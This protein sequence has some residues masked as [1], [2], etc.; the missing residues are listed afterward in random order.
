MPTTQNPT[1]VYGPDPPPDLDDTMD[2]YDGPTLPDEPIPDGQGGWYGDDGTGIHPTATTYSTIVVGTSTTGYPTEYATPTPASYHR[3]DYVDNDVTIF[4]TRLAARDLAFYDGRREWSD[5]S[6]SLD[7]TANHL[8]TA[9]KPTPWISGYQPRYSWDY[10]SDLTGNTYAAIVPSMVFWTKDRTQTAYY[11]FEEVFNDFQAHFGYDSYVFKLDGYPAPQWPGMVKTVRSVIGSNQRP[12]ERDMYE[13]WFIRT[14]GQLYYLAPFTYYYD[15]MST[16]PG[17]PTRFATTKPVRSTRDDP[18]VPGDASVPSTDA[19]EGVSDDVSAQINAAVSAALSSA[20]I[21]QQQALLAQQAASDAD[22]SQALA[23]QQQLLTAQL[24]AAVASAIAAGKLSQQQAVAAQKA[25]D[26]AATGAA[27]AADD[28]QDAA[29]LAQAVATAVANQAATDATQKQAAVDAQKAADA[30]AQQAAVNA[31][32]LA[33]SLAQQRAVAD[34]IAA[35]AARDQKLYTMPAFTPRVGVTVGGSYSGPTFFTNSSLS[36]MDYSH[37]WLTAFGGFV[38]TGYTGQIGG[39]STQPPIQVSG[40]ALGLY[41][42]SSKLYYSYTGNSTYAANATC[43]MISGWLRAGIST[44]I[45]GWVVNATPSGSSTLQPTLVTTGYGFTSL[46][47]T[48]RS[49]ST[50]SSTYNLTSSNVQSEILANLTMNGLNY[51]GFIYDASIGSYG[52]VTWIS[53]I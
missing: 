19:L 38:V 52:Q 15:K 42:S 20:A 2:H 26:D 32:Y 47:P 39:F 36:G 33:D 27:L 13:S 24:N 21:T 43:S 11:F 1:P 34:A 51:I 22:K 37:T 44:Q 3:V 53:Q 14:Y 10:H 45:V 31:Q 7:P 50:N 29:T 49:G 5:Y 4:N 48:A 16:A 35:Q 6:H 18:V 30:S 12:I 8:W 46:S 25:A 41:D 9:D 40:Q 23:A 28:A 17:R